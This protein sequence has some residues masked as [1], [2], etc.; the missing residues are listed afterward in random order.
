MVA[1]ALHS[2][3]YE[4]VWEDIFHTGE[5][6]LHALLRHKIDSSEGL[7]QI[8]G[9]C[10]GTPISGSD[11]DGECVSYTQ[12]EAV[13]AGT[14]GKK[15]WFMVLDETYPTDP[16]AEEEPRLRKV[17]SAYRD[18]VMGDRTVYHP[19][20]TPD[21]L[22]IKVLQLRDELAPLRRRGKRWMLTV[23]VFLALLA[24]GMLILR[25]DLERVIYGQ[26]Q[27]S[28][29]HQHMDAALA[30][31]REL[32]ETSLKGGSE[33][34]L[35]FNYD[36][37]IQLIAARHGLRVA[38]LKTFLETNA[39]RALKS[40]H[41]GA[42]EK[43]SALREAGRFVEA[44][45]LALQHAQ[46]MESARQQQSEGEVELWLEV[47]DAEME[48]GH[49]AQARK[50]VEKA[51]SLTNRDGDSTA[52][53]SANHALGRILL[54]QGQ[55]KDALTL[56]EE[57]V[58]F[59]SNIL[60]P[61]HPD[62]LQ[63]RNALAAAMVAQGDLVA[64]EN[65]FR[66]VLMI[67]SRVLGP[68]HRDTLTSRSN[69]VSWI[70]FSNSRYAEAEQELRALLVIRERVL[71]PEHPDT[72]T[73]RGNLGT[74]LMFHGKY[75]ESE[76]E[77]RRCIEIR[78][79]VLGPEHPDTLFSWGTVAFAI[80]EQGRPEEAEREIRACLAAQERILGP[81]HPDTLMTR[82]NLA[83]ILEGLG[84]PI[85]AEQEIRAV[86][87][88]RERIQESNHPDMVQICYNFAVLLC[89]QGRLHEALRFV[90]RAEDGR[91]PLPDIR[92]NREQI[93]SL[94]ENIERLISNPGDDQ[95]C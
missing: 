82:M 9:S 52:W 93:V 6:D 38:A 10:F 24:V 77:Q 89:R 35:Q 71:G 20:A 11:P 33:E 7:I 31:I 18:R 34:R 95:G 62:T 3:G 64:A 68:E 58:P 5:G 39:S 87:I 81:E 27:Q 70:L 91:T 72:L 37:S 57:L 41:A 55:A 94:R 13:Y 43:I 92:P 50:Y 12:F 16:H 75:S 23:I 78:A 25:R 53:A 59:R 56:Y 19:A 26:S 2:L 36:V 69:L 46:H 80:S 54:F 83:L 88:I 40:V 42:R 21:A 14:K 76:I 65:E 30:D 86:L 8:V 1:N 85:E 61:E 63:S 47:A 79:R 17:Q 74:A 49:Y 51:V 45:N 22:K 15:V 60:G 29:R 4:P 28:E 48:L 66:A 90:R 32:V 73:T 84:Q 67:R 44:R